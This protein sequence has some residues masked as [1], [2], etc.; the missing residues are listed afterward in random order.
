MKT[1]LKTGPMKNYILFLLLSFLLSGNLLSQSCL[2]G[3]I[4]FSSQSQ[5][6][7][8]SSNYP[9]CKT[10]AGPVEINSNQITNLFG[11]SQ[12][13][14]IGGYLKIWNGH[15]LSSLN[16]LENLISIGGNVDIS[17][18]NAIESLEGLN[19][20]ASING[21]LQISDN[22]N[23]VSLDGIENLNYETIT[24]FRLTGNSNLKTCG[25]SL[26]VCEIIASDVQ[27][28]I[29]GNGENC[30]SP[31]EIQ[32]ICG[33]I[34]KVQFTVF[35]DLNENKLQDIG[36]PYVQNIAINIQSGGT[37]YSEIID[38]NLVYLS[39]DNYIIQFKPSDNLAWE[40]TT[41]SSS[42]HIELTGNNGDA[43]VDF[44][45]KLAP[46]TCFL[47]G[48]SLDSQKQID[49]FSIKY[50]DCT[51]IAGYLNINDSDESVNS[52]I[53][54]SQITAVGG[55]L[56]INFINGMT[57][58]TGLNNISSV[59]EL[60]VLDN[61]DILSLTGLEG[62]TSANSIEISNNDALVSLV[63]LGNINTTSSLKIGRNHNLTSL[64]GLESFTALEELNVE[65]NNSLLSLNGLNNLTEVGKFDIKNKLLDNYIGLNQLKRIS[66]DFN[67]TP[68]H[69]VINFEGLENL[70]RIGGNFR[71]QG[72]Y[73]QFVLESMDGLNNLKRIEGSLIIVDN[74]TVQN[75]TAL[76]NLTY[77]GDGIN[78]SNST[79]LYNLEGLE[80][81]S[82]INGQFRLFNNPEITSL[83][84]FQSLQANSIT[85]MII[86]Q[87]DILSICDVPFVCDFLSTENLIVIQ[88]NNPG[89][90]S[91][92]EVQD[93]CG[94]NL[95]N[96]NVFQDLNDNCNFND[97]ETPLKNWMVQADGYTD[98]YSLTDSLGNYTLR[99]DTGIF[100]LHLIEPNPY[101][102]SC[103]DGIEFTFD[104]FGGNDSLDFPASDLYDCPALT[105]DVGTPFLR[106]CFDNV[107][108]VNYCN[109][110]TIIAEDAYAEISFDSFLDIDTASIPYTIVDD[111]Y[112]FQLGDIAVGEC[113]SFTINVRV[114]CDAL[115]SQTHCVEAHI[116]PDTFCNPQDPNWSGASLELD[117]ACVDDEVELSI[118]NVG[119][120][121]MTNSLN[122]I[123]IEDQL[124]MSPGIDPPLPIGGIK[125]LSRP[126]NGA[127]YRLEVN[128]ILGHPILQNPSIAIEGC[129]SDTTLSVSLGYINLFSEYDASPFVS[130]DCQE[131]IGSYDPND[132][133]AFPKG[134]GE[135]HFIKANTDIEYKIRF[136]NT[137]TDTAFNIVI[138]DT[139]SNF[140][141]I[142]TLRLGSSSHPYTTELGAD[143]LVQ[144]T[145]YNIMLPDSN[146]NE[147]ASHGFI[148]FKIR[149]KPNLP[150]GTRIYN[151]ADI[152]FDFNDPIITNETWHTIGDEI[153]GTCILDFTTQ[154]EV[155]NFALHDPDYSEINCNV[156]IHSGIDDPITN[157]N[158]FSQINSINGFLRIED[159]ELLTNLSG[160]ENLTSVQRF[161]NI[162]ANENLVNLEGLNNLTTINSNLN[163][164]NNP[165][166]ETLSGLDNISA[167]DGKLEL[168]NNPKLVNIS[169]L[170]GLNTNSINLLKI[171]DNNLLE[172]CEEP[173]VC[174]YLA[175]Q[176]TATISNNKLGCNTIEEI[177]FRCSFSD[178]DQDGFY[179]DVD[180]DDNNAEV[181]PDATE[182]PYNEIDDDCNEMTLDD[183]LDQDGFVLAQD[184][185][186]MNPDINSA[187]AEIPYNGI[188]DDCNQMTLD[189]DLDQDGFVLAEDCDDMNPNINADATEIPYNGTDDDCNQMTVDDDLDQDGFVLAED[190]DDMNPN[191]NADATEIPYNGID[192]DCNE[193]TLDDDLD[194]DG[195]VL[196]ED[197]D[198]MNPNINA[199]ATEIPNNNIDEDCDG[200]DGGVSTKR[201]YHAQ[202]DIFPNPTSNKTQI[203]LSNTN[204]QNVQ[205]RVFNVTGKLILM[206]KLNAET[207]VDLSKYPNGI[208]IFSISNGHQ[209][210][211]EKVLKL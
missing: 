20:L 141:D 156:Y 84:Y 39:P 146:I 135:E 161:C 32:V 53:G 197:C 36:E 134:Y 58:L 16:G 91:I 76:Q 11:L 42:F 160:L 182:I 193:T 8:F 108:S 138:I 149:Q 79:N 27:T 153:I 38:N 147:V 204:M 81:L 59:A 10:I 75:L 68:E 210:R 43:H 69:E 4:I 2:P 112:Q 151:K 6:D 140:L 130:I 186:D 50:P 48:L 102:T 203:V 211:Q 60:V 115:L 23:L 206:Q 104:A 109:Q 175:N 143:G 73:A 136:Q 139:L 55:P 17:F 66:G 31:N 96:G 94:F 65:E 133:M 195:F 176:G 174:H 118:K 145:F 63:G 46:G 184:C 107:Y 152:Y 190:C 123:V 99:V 57:S 198:D 201:F 33:G 100:S 78:I 92:E 165:D 150:I 56:T 80:N 34:P 170:N 124:I 192:D 28:Y 167:L 199:D 126:A 113:G 89:C 181:N 61:E 85:E 29:S 132:K 82:E 131:N 196:T 105:I 148:K 183:D 207:E 191:I 35:H 37:Y 200:I 128:Q 120:G 30:N 86:E 72:G 54:L 22:K 173:I 142:S 40:L 3:G 185:D 93:S 116:Y 97:G 209:I 5:I 7:N 158:A 171:I 125:T 52:L 144:F 13:E 121:A 106:R 71:I 162:E 62:L 90:N 47:E 70:E 24:Y 77:I 157:L 114:S 163:I 159:N 168:Q 202:I 21:S 74:N 15:N 44:G 208:Y 187:I 64:T 51:I 169:A 14:T 88:G 137:G 188:D 180:C 127:T 122:Y 110:G 18:Y 117:A 154:T 111:W 25:E 41:D 119:N 45:V 101:W 205:L 178:E 166:L 172:Y 194:Q 98:F 87:N 103:V 177:I 12:L 83:E 189:D 26:K 129:T 67:I 49:S 155:N 1:K 19:N 95:I 179:S 164:K 9:G